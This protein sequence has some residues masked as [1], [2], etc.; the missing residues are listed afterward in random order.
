MVWT[1][2]NNKQVPPTEVDL[3][4]EFEMRLIDMIEAGV[5]KPEPITLRQAIIALIKHTFTRS[6]T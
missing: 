1:M 6:N 4:D 2:N 3:H 5:A